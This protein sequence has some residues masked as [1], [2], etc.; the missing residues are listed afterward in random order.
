MERVTNQIRANTIIEFFQRVNFDRKKT[1]DHFLEQNVIRRTIE[2]CIKRFIETGS[3]EFKAIPGRPI[4]VNT[5]KNGRRVIASLK[6]NPSKSER[7]MAQSLRIPKTSVHRIK[8]TN[9][10]KTFTKKKC[11]KYIKD[12][13]ARA[14]KGCR[15]LYKK[16]I[17]SGGNF[18]IVMDDETYVP[19]DPDQVQS[20]EFYSVVPGHELPESAKVKPVEKYPKK[21][22][23]WQAIAQDGSVSKP[24]I[25]Q[26][27]MKSDDYLQ[28]CV[29][30]ILIPFIKSF[31]KPVLF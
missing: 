30:P 16:L 14:E 28:K 8:A 31:N 12:Q 2:R 11:P 24:Y 5:K 27:T 26:G 3:A 23:V 10:V 17:P 29:I 6:R 1:L 7:S 21:F 25:Q 13:A 9:G 19:A 4:T 20:K 15:R 18:L 22:L